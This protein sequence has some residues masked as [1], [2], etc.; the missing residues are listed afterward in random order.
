MVSLKCLV[1]R[2]TRTR[3]IINVNYIT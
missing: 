1:K 3:D 2:S